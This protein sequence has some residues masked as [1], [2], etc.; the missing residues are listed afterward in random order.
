[1]TV[2]IEFCAQGVPDCLELKPAFTIRGKPMVHPINGENFVS[3]GGLPFVR[4][5]YF[6]SL[7]VDTDSAGADLSRFDDDWA[8]A[9][10]TPDEMYTDIPDGSYDAVIEEARLTETGSTGRPM[11][12]WKLRIRGPQAVNR[13][14]TKNRVVTENTL[15]YLREDLDKCGLHV[16]R[17]SELPARL[18][19]LV[20]RPIGLDKRT[21]DGRANFYFRRPSNRTSP[22]TL[23]DVPF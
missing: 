8:K 7:P 17:L 13:V 11:V 20:D 10:V 18:G 6:M 15:A 16:S 22:V 12:T 21:K 19:E 23:D 1:L 2:I 9:S 4:G 14:L 3:A 5:G